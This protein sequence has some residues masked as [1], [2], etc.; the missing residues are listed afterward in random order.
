[1]DIP[2]GGAEPPVD[3][4]AVTRSDIGHREDKGDNS[5]HRQPEPR[6]RT[7]K[8][9]DVL[10]TTALTVLAVVNIGMTT[11][12]FAASFRAL[13]AWAGHH[14]YPGVWA[15]VWPLLIDGFIMVGESALVVATVRRWPARYVAGAVAIAVAGLAASIAANV[16]AAAP[17]DIPTRLTS[18]VP[19]VVAFVSLAVGLIVV[20]LVGSAPP[21]QGRKPVSQPARKAAA[22][23]S[24]PKP[25]PATAPATAHAVAGPAQRPKLTGKKAGA[26]EMYNEDSSISGAEIA[27]RLDVDERTGQRWLREFRG[28]LAAVPDLAPGRRAAP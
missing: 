1:M 8:A 10:G 24:K 15:V 7:W 21:R 12:S 28:T 11:G 2:G 23:A 17:A 19:P 18:A 13:H 22:P 26:L 14:G 27:R 25:A 5:V 16:G 6:E 9:A 4:K 20:K 3:S